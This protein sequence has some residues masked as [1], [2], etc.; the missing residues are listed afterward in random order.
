MKKEY[1]LANKQKI[2]EYQRLNK[3]SIDAQRRRYY[4]ENKDYISN[5][6]RKY[7]EENRESILE[8]KKQWRQQNTDKTNASRAKRRALKLQATPS[9]V[10]RDS[11]IGMYKLA[12]MFNR[13]GIKL[14]VDHIVPLQSDTV[15]GLHCESNLQLLPATDNNSKGNRYWPDMW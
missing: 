3:E 11:L 5:R 9:W 1:Y 10:D 6:H 12:L 8:V 13:T 15:C 7:Y 2:K 14:Q 4:N